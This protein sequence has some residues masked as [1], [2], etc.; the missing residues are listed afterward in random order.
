MGKLPARVDGDMG[1]VWD[2]EKI[3]QER[4]D[5]WPGHWDEVFILDDFEE[6]VEGWEAARN[7][8]V[9]HMDWIDRMDGWDLLTATA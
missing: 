3:L 7:Q 1:E 8:Y 2:L 6:P 4:K 9:E 5:P